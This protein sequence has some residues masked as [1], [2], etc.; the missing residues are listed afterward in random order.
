MIYKLHK[1]LPPDITKENT[2]MQEINLHRIEAYVQP[3][4]APSIRL[5]TRLGF[6]EE[7][8]LHKYVQT[9]LKKIRLAFPK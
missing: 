5:L 7:G 1:F 6:Q 9:L 4:N 2:V 3:D 8:Y